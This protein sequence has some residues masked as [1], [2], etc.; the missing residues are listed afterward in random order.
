MR[1][2]I[3]FIIILIIAFAMGA[4]ST[5]NNNKSG[6]AS[7]SQNEKKKVLYWVAP[8]NPSYRSDK[9][10]KSPMGMELEPVYADGNADDTNSV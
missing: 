1:K 5:R 8:M 3:F 7:Q 10:G 9:P 2:M 6:S 4:L